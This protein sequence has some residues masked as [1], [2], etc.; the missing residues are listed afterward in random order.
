MPL[1]VSEMPPTP[2]PAHT[3]GP[4]QLGMLQP[5]APHAFTIIHEPRQLP[6]QR[7]QRLCAAQQRRHNV[8]A[9]RPP[10]ALRS[11]VAAQACGLQNMK[12]GGKARRDIRRK[13]RRHNAQPL[14]PAQSLGALVAAQACGMYGGT[15]AGEPGNSIKA[16]KSPTHRQPRKACT[17][18]E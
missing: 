4:A 3:C 17:E 15:K 11:L 2:T 5:A 7:Q 14:R 12:K 13:A 18:K 16:P 10:Q 8:Q 1:G 9:F 6:P